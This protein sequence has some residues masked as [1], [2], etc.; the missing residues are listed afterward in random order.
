MDLPS[1]PEFKSLL[2]TDPELRDDEVGPE[3]DQSGIGDFFASN[4]APDGFHDNV[5]RAAKFIGKHGGIRIVLVTSGGT[6]VPL[7]RVRE[8]CFCFYRGLV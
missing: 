5:S 3:E 7:E 8:G 1:W 4:R 6:T 2:F